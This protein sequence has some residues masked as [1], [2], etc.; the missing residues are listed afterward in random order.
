M[1]FSASVFKRLLRIHFHSRNQDSCACACLRHAG[2]SEN[3]VSQLPADSRAH[4]DPAHADTARGPLQWLPAIPHLLPEQD[5]AD[6]WFSRPRPNT[7]DGRQHR[8]GSVAPVAR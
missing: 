6:R 1:T 7:A 8:A 3:A 2:Q 4:A 5:A